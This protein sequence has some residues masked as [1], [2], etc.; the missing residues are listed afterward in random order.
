MLTTTVLTV[1]TVWM[2]LCAGA[3]LVTTA[4]CRSGHLEDD[5]WS[6]RT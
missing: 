2:V 6:T 3:L 5:H 1:V 4:L